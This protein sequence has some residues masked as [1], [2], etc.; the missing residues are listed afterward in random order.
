MESKSKVVADESFVAGVDGCPGGWVA[1]RVSL[2][3][4]AT[5]VEIVDLPA[6]L[7]DRPRGLA[8]LAIDIP[9]G[10]LDGPR[11]CDRAARKL[12]GPVRR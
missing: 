12:L 11:A 3:S 5:D 4:R 8:A 10:L 1:F 2:D 6:I 9:I 7:R